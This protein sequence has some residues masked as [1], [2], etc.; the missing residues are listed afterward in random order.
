MYIWC[1]SKEAKHLREKLLITTH[2][3]YMYTYMYMKAH[4]KLIA[5]DLNNG[6]YAMIALPARL[7]LLH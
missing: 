3:M 2:Y 1:L 6:D 5:V 7:Q 4:I